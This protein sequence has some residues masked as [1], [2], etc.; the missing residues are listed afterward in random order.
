[1]ANNLNA[2]PI[3]LDT[4]G[5]TSAWT[6]PKLVRKFQWV[7]A[8]GD[9]ADGDTC[10]MVVNGVTMTGYVERPTDVGFQ[11]PVLWEIDFGSDGIT[12]GDFSLT[13][14]GVGHIY[15]WLV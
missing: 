14:M 10:V 11:T 8:T 15:I 1:M 5:A 13:T 2:N 7:N 4:V 3:F 12:W 6:K 9:I